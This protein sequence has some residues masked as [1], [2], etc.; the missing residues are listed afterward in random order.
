MSITATPRGRRLQPDERRQHILEAARLLFSQRP[1]ASV[2]TRDVAEAAGV[3]RS[4]VHHYFGG[5]AEVF[6]AVVAQGGAAL[7]DVRSA[8]TET[9]FEERIAHNIAAGLDLVGDNRETWLAAMSHGPDGPD[10][11][12]G[13]LIG[14]VQERFV[15]RTLEVNTDL[16]EDT[17]SARF[18]LRCFNA[19]LIEGTRAWLA[20]DETR[21]ATQ[22]LLIGAFRELVLRT[23][24]ALQATA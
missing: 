18:A 16:I 13:A 5:I 15:A 4:L 1:Y 3:A 14:A 9:P 20:G 10:P 7:A 21:E 19:F 24:P 22:V 8:G 6:I 2:S 12:I 17:P 11:R 23:I